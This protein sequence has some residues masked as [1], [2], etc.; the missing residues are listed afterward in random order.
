MKV[1]LVAAG[2]IFGVLIGVLFVPLISKT[3][4]DWGVNEAMAAIT[5]AGVVVAFM[6]PSIE[7]WLQ[8]WERRKNA[9]MRADVVVKIISPNYVLFSAYIEN[10]GDVKI[11]T[12]ITNLY[13]DSGIPEI[14][15]MGKHSYT[16]YKF[17][18]LL[19]HKN[20]EKDIDCIL[21]TNCKAENCK[22]PDELKVAEDSL[23]TNQELEHLS[24]HSVK[25]YYPKEKFS[26]DLVMQLNPG[27]YR[28]T[29]VA[30]GQNTDCVCATK[31]FIVPDRQTVIEG[32]N[33]K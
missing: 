24:L 28:V 32:E 1:I 21:A 22:Y 9:L 2:L 3:I 26:E 20:A 14:K 10:I 23:G 12:K 17:P 8:K 30:T 27:V 31:Q 25:Y 16:A 5:V 6:I 18:F 7:L 29:L 15:K 33:P 13:I 19:K 4:S 11:E